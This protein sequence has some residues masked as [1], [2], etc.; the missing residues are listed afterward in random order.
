MEQKKLNDGEGMYDQRIP[1]LLR[2]YSGNMLFYHDIK[3]KWIDAL[4]HYNNHE[5]RGV[6]RGNLPEVAT[7]AVTNL[8]LEG[9]KPEDV[10]REDIK[11]K[12]IEVLEGE[13]KLRRIGYGRT[14]EQGRT[15][16]R[17]SLIQKL[18]DTIYDP[19]EAE[20]KARGVDRP[21]CDFDFFSNEYISKH[22]P[23]E[24]YPESTSAG[25]LDKKKVI[26]PEFQPIVDE[27]NGLVAQIRE[28]SDPSK[29]DRDKLDTLLLEI[30]KRVN[31]YTQRDS[32]VKFFQFFDRTGRIPTIEELEKILQEQK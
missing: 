10:Y 4:F 9:F 28:M 22:Y 29:V 2:I 12:C 6:L 30:G 18:A 15:S 26:A 7:S 25:H 24:N 13:E 21:V 17:Q 16:E 23:R 20:I 19:L 32:A 27:F 11:E 8:T 1:E 14:S 5:N 3:N 31:R